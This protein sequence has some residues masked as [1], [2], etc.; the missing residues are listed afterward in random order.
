MLFSRCHSSLSF[1]TLTK[2]PGCWCSRRKQRG[3]HHS[4]SQHCFNC[5]TFVY[6]ACFVR[7]ITPHRR[8]K[9]HIFWFNSFNFLCFISYKMERLNI[10]W[11]FSQNYSLFPFSA[12]YFSWAAFSGIHHLKVLLKTFPLRK[13]TICLGKKW[14]FD[15]YIYC[16]LW[17]CLPH[18]IL[19]L[20]SMSV[21][22]VG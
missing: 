13:N 18:S 1:Q 12:M 8:N 7:H 5:T 6:F 22:N 2:T 10:A 17:Q 14:C 15:N 3:L 16:I 21:F 20:S 11:F 19:T 9:K 4:R